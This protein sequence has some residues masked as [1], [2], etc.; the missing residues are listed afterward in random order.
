MNIRASL[1]VVVLL[2]LAALCLAADDYE[3]D[4]APVAPVK[5]SP[6]RPSPL[7]R[8]AR[9]PVI[10]RPSPKTSAQKTTTT[11]T[12]EP[13]VEYEDEEGEEG[14]A[15]QE[16]EVVVTTTTEAP[17]KGGLKTGVVRP[18]RSNADLIERLKRRREQ[19]QKGP[20]SSAVTTTTTQAPSE[21]KTFGKGGRKTTGSN[22][23]ADQTGSTSEKK[24]TVN[25]RRFTTRGKTTEAPVEPE[26][27]E[28]EQPRARTFGRGRRF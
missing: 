1:C 3:Y 13:P 27:E 7:F 8:Q 5:P 24:S 16:E 9:G 4:D 15:E 21:P 25:N 19:Q 28:Q 23:I 2:G 10:G 22:R 14:A 17:K 6:P 11:T 20:G 26:V 12:P 18:F